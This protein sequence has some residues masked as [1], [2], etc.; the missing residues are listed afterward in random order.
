MAKSDFLK[1]YWQY[2]KEGGTMSMASF[3]N[4][5]KEIGR[6]EGKSD[7]GLFKLKKVA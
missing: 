2:R 1:Q 4:R 7:K 3:S 6:T 5:A